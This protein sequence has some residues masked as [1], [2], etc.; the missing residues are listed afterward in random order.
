MSCEASVTVSAGV[1]RMRK[2]T[3]STRSASPSRAWLKLS[4][5]RA[6][7]PVVNSENAIAATES[8]EST[9]VRRREG[10]SRTTSFMA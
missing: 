6:Y 4:A 8:A 7:N 9:G 1:P 10:A 3:I 2:A 5:T